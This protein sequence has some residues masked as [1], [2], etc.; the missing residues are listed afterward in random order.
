MAAPHDKF[1][2]DRTEA[3]ILAERREFGPLVDRLRDG[4]A[5]AAEQA[6]AADIIEGK[7][8]VAAHRPKNMKFD[9]DL[10]IL[11]F[12]EKHRE[13]HR[14]CGRLGKMEQAVAAAIDEFSE[15][16]IASRTQIYEAR[17]H[18]LRLLKEFG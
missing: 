12:I 3:L 5:S 11:D 14:R 2:F 15:W 7:H 8:K 13:E 6:L 9:R 18:A 16:G 4:K 1:D 10:A 17:R